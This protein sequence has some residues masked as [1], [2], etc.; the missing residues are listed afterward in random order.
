MERY[1]EI[2]FE[3]VP[4][5]TIGLGTGRWADKSR[6]RILNEYIPPKDLRFR[7]DASLLTPTQQVV[8]EGVVGGYQNKQ[9][10]Y[11]NNISVETVKS[12]M[13]NIAEC[14]RTEGYNIPNTRSQVRLNIIL[15]LLHAGEL[16]LRDPYI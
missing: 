5:E 16:E 14:L 15:A 11:K 12:H 8:V 3:N 10:A 7:E 1:Q 4:Q 6:V 9:I 13:Y 2:L